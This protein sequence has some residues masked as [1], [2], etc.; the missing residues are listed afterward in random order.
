MKFDFPDE[1][2]IV[3]SDYKIPGLREGPKSGARWI[4]IFDGA[5]NALGHDIGAFMTSPKNFHKPYTARLYFYC[6]NTITG[7]ESCI[8]GLEVAID[9]RIKHLE[10][11]E[12]SALVIY[13]VNSE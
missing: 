8:L 6:T 3:I 1:D 12:A 7:Y 11:Y 5:S 4:L 13:Q 9:L 2:I 10:V